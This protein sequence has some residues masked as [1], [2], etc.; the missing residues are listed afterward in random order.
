[1]NQIKPNIFSIIGAF[2]LA[3]AI[4]LGA[5]NAHGMENFVNKGL[6]DIKYIKTFHTG[7][8]YMFISSLGLLFLGVLGNNKMLKWASIFI[9]SGMFIFSFSLFILSFNQLLGVG[10]KTSGAI[11][12]IGGLLMALC[13]IM[14]AFSIIQLRNK[15]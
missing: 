11:A 4:V 10:F 15:A 12:P 9:T 6:M 3:H 2:S 14:A 7:V 1:M 8:E 5:W 13:W